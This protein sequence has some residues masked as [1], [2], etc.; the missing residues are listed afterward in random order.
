PPWL[1]KKTGDQFKLKSLM[2]KGNRVGEVEES[3]VYSEMTA[4]ISPG[5]ILLLYTD[6]LMENTNTAGEQYGKK[7]VREV[8]EGSLAAGPRG[9]IDALKVAYMEYN[10]TEKSLDD[11]VT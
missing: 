11:D 10:G 8:V 2:P 9:V 3:G 5:D 6:G 1:Y 4:P 7:R